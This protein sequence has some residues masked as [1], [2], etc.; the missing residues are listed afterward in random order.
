MRRALELARRHRG[1]TSP[2]PCV[3]AVIVR[4]G[5]VVGEGAHV[6]AGKP[7]AEAVALSNA[8]ERA[9]GATLYCTL[10]PCNHHGKTPPCTEAIIAAGVSRVVFAVEDPN[11]DVAGKGAERLREAGVEVTSSILEDE[12]HHLN[13]EFFHFCRTSRPWVVLKMA[14]SLDGKVATASGESQWITS[15]ESRE[16]AH[17]LRHEVDAV[18]VGAGTL[19]AD[20]PR[21]TVRIPGG[22]WKQPRRIVL[23]SIGR[24]A[25]EAAL[26]DPTVTSRAILAT[27]AQASETT[28][29]AFESRGV[30]VLVAE[31]DTM[32]RVDLSSFLRLLGQ[33]GIQS[34]LVEGGP[35]VAGSFLE[36]DLVDEV[37]SYLSPSLIGG[38]EAKNALAGPGRAVLSERLWLDRLTVDRAGNDI[39]V[40]GLVRQPSHSTG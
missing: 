38:D 19:T 29:V 30:D 23:D 32:G 3:G 36:S 11:P 2:N 18:V 37:V 35:R 34:L 9:R 27:T 25:P 6:S 31:N 33:R 15:P 39:V 21:L 12:A 40:R 7:H 5:K 1:F 13:R 8:G 20:N 14:T 16:H 28:L 4:D 17:R 10:E 24:A 26:F 22:P